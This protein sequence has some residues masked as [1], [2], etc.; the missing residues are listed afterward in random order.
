[1]DIEFDVTL[2][3]PMFDGRAAGLAI[4]AADAIRDALAEEGKR[5]VYDHFIEDIRVNQ[6]VFLSTITAIDATT[7]FSWAGRSG[8]VYV[9][10]VYVSDPEHERVVTTELSMYGPW[11]EGTGSRNFTTRY[12]GY[13]GFRKATQDLLARA[14]AIGYEVSA[15]YIKA[16]NF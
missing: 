14:E 6:G 13:H 4:L 12:K 10:P 2:R 7:E 16:M 5:L 1:M 3:G 9:M 8:K 11:L 15:P